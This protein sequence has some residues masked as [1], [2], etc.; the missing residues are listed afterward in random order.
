MSFLGHR[1]CKYLLL[2]NVIITNEVMILFLRAINAYMQA[3][4]RNQQSM[5][6]FIFANECRLGKRYH[7]ISTK[8]LEFAFTFR[9]KSSIIDFKSF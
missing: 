7:L 4:L 2:S 5:G 1:L 6:E 9:G 8:V 3:I